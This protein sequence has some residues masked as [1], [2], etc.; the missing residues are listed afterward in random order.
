MIVGVV[1]AE[2]DGLFHVLNGFVHVP[3][4]W[5]QVDHSQPV[6]R[7]GVL[8]VFL[9]KYLE[10]FFRLRKASFPIQRQSL[11]ES[12]GR[13]KP[14]ES[15]QNKHRFADS[16]VHALFT[17]RDS[18]A[19]SLPYFVIDLDFGVDFKLTIDRLKRSRHHFRPFEIFT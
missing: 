13:E 3:E 5:V 2:I 11:F 17:L 4:P 9:E 10:D 14:G 15:N 8:A 16:E 12:L 6:M 18:S 1:G 7:L 19:R